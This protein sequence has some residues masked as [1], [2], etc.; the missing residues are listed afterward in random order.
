MSAQLISFPFDRTKKALTLESEKH[1][2]SEREDF[3]AA[4]SEYV[5]MVN[6]IEG[7]DITESDL[8]SYDE[9]KYFGLDPDEYLDILMEHGSMVEAECLAKEAFV[10]SH[11][12]D[13]VPP[14]AALNY[15]GTYGKSLPLCSHISY[16]PLAALTA[17]DSSPEYTPPTAA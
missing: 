14:V 12:W 2:A 8:L 16:N 6:D 9:C 5:M 1:Q 11:L 10:Y 15:A 7:R 4:V 17:N 13:V 3:E